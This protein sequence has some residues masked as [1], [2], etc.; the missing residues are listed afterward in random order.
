MEIQTFREKL[1]LTILSGLMLRHDQPGYSDMYAIH[2]AHGLAET[3]CKEVASQTS[4]PAESPATDRQQLKAEIAAIAS[5]LDTFGPGN[6]DGVRL[7]QYYSYVGRLRQ[8]SAV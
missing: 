2:E 3:W 5:E 4:E 6:C 1:M 8:L 7:K